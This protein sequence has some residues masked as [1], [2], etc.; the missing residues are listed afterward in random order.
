MEIRC[1]VSGLPKPQI[2]W[3][4]LNGELPANAEVK[5]NGNL[6]LK[7]L[8][9]I[10]AGVYKCVGRNELGSSEQLAEVR[11]QGKNILPKLYF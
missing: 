7:N 4:K 3:Y 1:K 10:D 8:S 6:V 9:K 2:T 11:V 5:E